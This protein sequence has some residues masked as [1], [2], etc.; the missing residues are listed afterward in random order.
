LHSSA[1]VLG[2][3]SPKHL[4][5]RHLLIC[6]PCP[7]VPW[8]NHLIKSLSRC[9][10]SASST[11]MTLVIPHSGHTRETNMLQLPFMPTAILSSSR[12]SSPRATV[13]ALQPAMPLC[14]S[15]QPKVLQLISKSSTMR[16]ARFTRK[17]SP[18]S[19]MPSSSLS[20]LICIAAI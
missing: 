16:P 10:P 5:P 11:Q 12:L 9:T 15:W 8:R 13:T 18:S 20:H 3:P 17:L 2:Q 7:Q 19:G 14:H 1:K 4:S 6:L